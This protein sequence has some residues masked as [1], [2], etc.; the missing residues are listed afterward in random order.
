VTSRRLIAT[1]A[2]V[3]VVEVGEEI[4]VEACASTSDEVYCGLLFLGG[5]HGSLD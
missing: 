4:V 2:Q 5:W 3:I 1:A